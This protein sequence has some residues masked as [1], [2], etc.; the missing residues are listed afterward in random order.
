M[1]FKKL[2]A[3]TLDEYSFG[4]LITTIF[5]LPIFLLPLFNISIDY[6]KNVLLQIA[7]VVSVIL[8]LI[9]RL[10]AGKLSVPKTY[11]LY[12]VPLIPLVF[13]IS[14]IYSSSFGVS[15]FGFGDEVGTSI[16]ILVL[17]LVLFLSSVYFKTTNR[18]FYLYSGILLSFVLLAAYHFSRLILGADFLSFGILNIQSASIIGKWNDLAVFSGFSAILSL[19]AIYL[20]NIGKKIKILMFIVLAISL[21]FIALVDFSLVW[22]LLGIFSLVI[23]VYVI[24]FLG[25]KSVFDNKEFTFEINKSVMLP[26]VISIVSVLFLIP[27]NP[28]SNFL[29][30][31][32]NISYIEARPSWNSTIDIVKNTWKSDI[33]LGSGPNKFS[34]QWGKYKTKSVNNTLF[35]KTNFNFGVGMIPS[36]AVTTG[37]L[38]IIVWIVFLSWLVFIGS[39][40]VITKHKNKTTHYLVFSSFIFTLYLWLVSIFY[41]PGVS[42]F[43]LAFVMTGVF[44]AY[45]VKS[46]NIKKFEFSFLDN[47]KIGFVSVLVIIILMITS[48]VGGYFFTQRF[49]S[50]YLFNKGV[51]EFNVK[52]NIALSEAKIL[53]ASK[54]YKSDVYYRTLSEIQIAKLSSILSKKNTGEEQTRTQFQDALGSAI[55][56]AKKAID[57]NKTNYVNWILLGKV[58]ESII[59]V[60]VDGAYENAVSAYN[61]ALVLNPTSPEVHLI[62]SRVEIS[63]G[64]LAKAKEHISEA[65]NLKNNYTEAI[66]LLSQ[67]QAGEGK[68]GDAIETAKKASLLSPNNIGIFFQL[69]FLRYQ[70]KDYK[71]AISALE[72][73]VILQ[74]VYSNAKYFLG[75]SYSKVGRKKD[76]I[77]QFKDIEYLNP[78]NKEVKKIL[79]N[80][81]KG[82]SL[83]TDPSA[84]TPEKRD[85]LPIEE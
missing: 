25:E 74:P 14:S 27:G 28:A 58:Y 8:W 82:I 11:L 75:L 84:A 23:F 36:F 65:L 37:L 40:F 21:F 80:L 61:Q 26:L 71:G 47:Q 55:D 72:R 68:L 79:S 46:E 15:M 10:K 32:L 6:T 77:A 39:K 35:W 42:M 60:G 83:F 64:D 24:S 76:A 67:I 16:S 19:F 78:D 63:K 9:A 56:A 33:L 50:A 66:F 34:E 3:L 44:I 38:G 2:K 22:V 29:A 57:T 73:A 7:V 51:K 30:N 70:N 12:F 5:L 1:S 52:G 13:F 17:F 62:L 53:K 49:V 4:V 54:L 48:T 45:L 41:V 81:V 20:P 85:K 31:K 69:G 43:A 18:V 59:L